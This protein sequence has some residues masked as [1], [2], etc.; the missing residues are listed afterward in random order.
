MVMKRYITLIGLFSF[1]WFLSP[2]CP[3]GSY[4]VLVF[5]ETQTLSAGTIQFTAARATPGATVNFGLNSTV[6]FGP[7]V[8]VRGSIGAISSTGTLINQGLI[9][10]DVAGGTI[11]VTAA[12]FTNVGILEELN[13]GNL[14]APGFP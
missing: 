10:A 7:G 14:I 11:K 4:S 6:T 9:S 1:D 12:T 2:P 5:D 3:M 8:S 13:G